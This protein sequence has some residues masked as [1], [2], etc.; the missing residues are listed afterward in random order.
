MKTFTDKNKKAWTIELTVGS[1]RRVKS[2]TT[3]DLFKVISLEKDGKAEMT[4]TL[5]RLI[6]DPCALVDVLYSLCRIQAEKEGIT[7]KDFGELFDADAIEAAANALVEEIILFSPAAKRKALTKIY[8]MAQRIA[9]KNEAELDKLLDNKELEKQLES[10]LNA[11]FTAAQ[12]SSESILTPSPS[13][14]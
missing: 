1:A 2:D 11:S 12:V 5:Q 4:D 3:I 8:T 7:D 14:S 13:D 9:A 6:E 10:R